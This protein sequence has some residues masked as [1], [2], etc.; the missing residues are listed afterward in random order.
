MPF[1]AWLVAGCCLMGPAAFFPTG[2]VDRPML[3]DAQASPGAAAQGA[4][5][6]AAP[7]KIGP[8]TLSGYL[9]FDGLFPIGDHNDAATGTFRVRRARAILSGNFTPTIG[10]YMGGD[11]A[12]APSLRDVYL[13]FKQLRFANVRAGQ[14]VTPFSLERITSS[15]QIE[16]I[17]RS[18]DRFTPSRDMGV[19]VFSS[20]P[21]WRGVSYSAAIVNGTGQNTA[22]NNDTKDYVGRLV[23]SVAR[24]SGLSV[25]AN[26]ASGRQPSGMRRRWGADVNFNHGAWHVASEYL[27]QA[28]DDWGAMSA[29]GYYLVASRKFRPAVA[30]PDF[31]MAEAVVRLVD[32][33]DPSEITGGV[34][35]IERRELQAGGNYYFTRNVRVMASAFVPVNRVVGAPR[36]TIVTRLQ[37]AF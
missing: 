25:G 4:E 16:A 21:F 13:T 18:I 23:W 32:I 6:E 15:V 10:W 30:G 1:V 35:G 12:G 9:Q 17:D 22:D 14:F 26:A 34:P 31:Y 37:F 24:V 20:T 3:A 33:R 11:L 19:M 8:V 7:L 28:Q 5:S 2:V 27:H 36:T 29:H